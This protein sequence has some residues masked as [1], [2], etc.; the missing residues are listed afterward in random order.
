M[1][2]LLSS[3]YHQLCEVEV[4]TCRFLPARYPPSCTH[5]LALSRRDI[6]QVLNGPQESAV[7]AIEQLLLGLDIGDAG[8]LVSGAIVDDRSNYQVNYSFSY[9]RPEEC[10]MGRQV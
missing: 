4:C 1:L 6:S 7:A 3:H 2:Y 10:S 5:G 9:T 8:V